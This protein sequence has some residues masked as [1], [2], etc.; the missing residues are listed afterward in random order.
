MLWAHLVSDESLTELHAFAAS[1]GIPPRAFDHDHYDVPENRHAD[2]VALGAEPVSGLDLA[3]RLEASGLRV[4]QRDKK[5][6][7]KPGD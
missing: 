2:L 3:R 1:A 5:P 4:K 7:P 6:K